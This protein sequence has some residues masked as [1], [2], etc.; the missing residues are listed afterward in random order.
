MNP[1]KN[2]NKHGKRRDGWEERGRKLRLGSPAFQRV[3]TRGFYQTRNWEGGRRRG[4]GG[5]SENFLPYT[6]VGEDRGKKRGG[7]T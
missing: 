2:N 4:D 3:A 1:N 6:G 7:G 5:L